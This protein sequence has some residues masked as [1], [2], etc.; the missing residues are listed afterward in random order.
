MFCYWHQDVLIGFNLCYQHGDMLIDK[1]IGL[2]YPQARQH[3]LYFVSWFANLDYAL[4]HGLKYY[5]A[6]WTDPQ[7]KA[8]LG[9]R[10]TLTRHLV[11]A[12][13]PLLRQL[14]TRFRHHFESDAH[15]VAAVS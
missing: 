10:F 13:H 3:N 7:V 4:A 2:R 11:W 9:A 15:A 1:Y 14:L 12:R 6:G 8:S 5:V